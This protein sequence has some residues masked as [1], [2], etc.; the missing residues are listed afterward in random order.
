MHNSNWK[1]NCNPLIIFSLSILQ[2]NLCVC[3]KFNDSIIYLFYTEKKTPFEYV[4]SLF[5][6][7]LVLHIS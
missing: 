6:N 2:L 3:E 7:Y 5:Y 4:Y 1:N